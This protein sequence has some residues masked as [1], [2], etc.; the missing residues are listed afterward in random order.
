MYYTS[1]KCPMELIKAEAK[2][3]ARGCNIA[4]I[5]HS[6]QAGVKLLVIG[7]QVM[8]KLEASGCSE[9]S[10][11][12]RKVC[13]ITLKIFLALYYFIHRFTLQSK[14]CSWLLL[15]MEDVTGHC[16][17]VCLLVT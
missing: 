4:D 12:Y 7:S 15:I 2:K 11:W 13:Y 14:T 5:T 6:Q 17:Y 1:K 9:V 10:R 16:W 3:Y 8:A